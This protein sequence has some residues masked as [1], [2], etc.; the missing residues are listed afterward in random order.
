MVLKLLGLGIKNYFYDRY[1]DFDCIIVVFSLVEI[2]ATYS[3][4]LNASGGKAL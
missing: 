3:N 2:I 4:L 1:N